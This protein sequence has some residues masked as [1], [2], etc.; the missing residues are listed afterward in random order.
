MG[1]E[2]LPPY[3]YLARQ[4]RQASLV[5]RNCQ[6]TSHSIL[7]VLDTSGSIGEES[8]K[9]MT[10]AVSSL[11]PLFC[12]P[13]QFAMLTFGDMLRLEFCFNCFDNTLNGRIAAGQAIINT[14]YRHG[15]RTR[16]GEAARCVC[17]ELLDLYKCGL[18]PVSCIDVVFI[19]DGLSNGGL[20]VCSEVRC[21]HNHRSRHINTYAIGINN[22]NEREIKCLSSYSNT[23]E[24]V[25]GFESFSEFVGY[26]NN[27]TARLTSPQNIENRKYDCVHRNN[28]LDH[29][30]R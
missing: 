8:Y 9:R 13:T 19:T 21:L 7:F 29:R 23:E 12:A 11:V 20:D 15:P 30:P 27:V 6:S 14:K 28:T 17:N 4:S 25:F 3:R 22:Y 10:T 24:V 2:W 18:A 16:T 1:R 5:N 26:L